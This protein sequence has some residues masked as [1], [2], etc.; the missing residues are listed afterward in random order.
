[1]S[2]KDIG[3]LGESVACKFLIQKGYHI[4]ER[5]YR[6]AVGE[7]DIIAKKDGVLR[8]IEVKSVSRESSQDISREIND[9][10]PEELVHRKKLETIAKVASFYVEGTQ[11]EQEDY[12]IDVVAVYLNVEKRMARCRL[13]ENVL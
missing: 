12:Q 11:W 7:I 8:F 5:N 2:T 4:L 6:I 9:Y 13:T 10:R 3:Y 1:M